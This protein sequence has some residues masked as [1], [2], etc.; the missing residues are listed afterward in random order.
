MN[1]TLERF[2]YTP[3]GVFGVLTWTGGHCYTI[4]EAWR[5]NEKGNSCIPIG[6]Y[7]VQRGQFPKHGEA[8][9]VQGVPGRSAILFHVANT[10]ADIE[11]C[12]GPGKR[13][14][15]LGGVWAVLDSGVAYNE[16]MRAHDGKDVL[17]LRII[18]NLDQGKLQ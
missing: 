1:I 14:G 8:F 15:A 18:N 6:T 5:N 10:V 7:R 11:G 2:A 17:T 16:F 4:E 3:M 12:I 9:E 13:L